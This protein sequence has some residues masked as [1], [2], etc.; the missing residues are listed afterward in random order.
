MLGGDDK[1]VIISE[2]NNKIKAVK[3]R[4]TYLS[5]ETQAPNFG[6]DLM[7]NPGGPL[8]KVY[9]KKIE[10]LYAKMDHLGDLLDQAVALDPSNEKVIQDTA[11]S[12]AVKVRDA[13]ARISRGLKE[14]AK[15]TKRELDV[16][17]RE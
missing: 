8:Y 17:W 15:A 13:A 12:Y 7:E 3:G 2:L 10:T 6:A 16:L 1:N 9:E 14:A 5:N 11:D 4:I